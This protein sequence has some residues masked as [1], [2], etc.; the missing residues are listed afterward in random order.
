MVLSQDCLGS[1]DDQSFVSS[2]QVGP[3]CRTGDDPVRG[4]LGIEMSNE[5]QTTPADSV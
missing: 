3:Q 1:L 5:G 4:R 2:C